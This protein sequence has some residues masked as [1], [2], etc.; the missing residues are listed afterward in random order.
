M[1]EKE[2]SYKM[3]VVKDIIDELNLE[4]LTEGEPDKEISVSDFNRPGLQFA[5]FYNYFAS[6]RIQIIGKAEWSYLE[7]MNNMLREERLNKFFP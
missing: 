5:G 4:V 1:I 7:C 3:V 2:G 6:E